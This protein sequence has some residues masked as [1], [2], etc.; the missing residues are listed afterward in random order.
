MTTAIAFLLAATFV[1]SVGGLALLVWA[2][3]NDQFTLGERA[4]ELSSP[5][6]RSAA[7][8]ILR[9]PRPSGWTC[10]ACAMTT[11]WSSPA[12]KKT[13]VRWM[14]PWPLAAGSQDAS[15][16]IPVLWWLMSSL[17]WL[18]VASILGVVASVKLHVP[19]WLVQDAALTFGRIRPAHLNA[20]AYGWSSMAGI[21][22]GIWL[23]PRLFKSPLVGGGWATAGAV[24][25]NLGV[26][27]G[28]LA[29]LAGRSDGLIWPFPVKCRATISRD[30]AR[31]NSYPQGVFSHTGSG[32]RRAE[33]YATIDHADIRGL[34][35]A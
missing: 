27:G 3:A 10:N 5:K 4:A 9:C 13:A 31:D 24:M 11:G 15:T 16:R 32:T 6:A 1:I 33:H 29:V 22:V 8:R 35:T 26:L 17:L 2:L 7:S 12:R 20:A 21:A 18:A 30:R 14:R 25:W 34:V 19:E 28:I 23:I